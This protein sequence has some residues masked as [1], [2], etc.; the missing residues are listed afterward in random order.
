MTDCFW[1]HRIMDKLVRD[2]SKPWRSGYVIRSSTAAPRSA[3]AS[4]S[5][6]FAWGLPL[7]GLL[8]CEESVRM[9]A[10][11]CPYPDSSKR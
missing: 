10:L 6:S 2:A 3:P 11:V 7:A 4:A 9:L 8:T 5:D 1:R